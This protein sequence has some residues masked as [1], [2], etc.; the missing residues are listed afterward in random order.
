VHFE[1]RRDDLHACRVVDG[2]HAV[3]EPGQALLEIDSFGLTTNNI[4][5]AVFG[6]AMSYW[7][8]FPADDGWG[9]VPVWGFADV[10][11]GGDTDLAGGSRVFGYFPPSSTLVVLPE[12]IDSRGF[13]DAS[14]HRANLPAAYN[15]YALVEGLP[16]YEQRFE[17]QQMLLWPL[18]FTSFL[19]D[20]F[21]GGEELF[22]A[23]TAIVSSASSKTA[24]SAAF[25][26]ARREG[27]EVVG[28]TSP[29]RVE[30]VEG[31]GVYDHVVGYPEVSSL[32]ATPAVYVDIAG[33]TGVRAAVHGHFGDELRHSA[34]VGATHWDAPADQGG[35]DLP[36]PQPE[37]FFAPDH[38]RRRS[39]DWG[40]EG[41]DRRVAEA[42]VPF[43]EWASGWLEIVRGEGPEAVQ[44]AYLE[45]L[46][47]RTDPSVGH[48]LRP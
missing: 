9:R 4:T 33:D 41:L 44:A 12:R 10:A 1:V 32:P 24:L 23:G 48:V 22:G 47:G 6:E 29:S 2:D 35:G 17:E 20:D 8:F 43:V 37:F 42:W 18:F 3:L 39:S 30:F 27:V 19:I 21:L 34:V 46:D 31:L 28:L 26:L 38:V 40:R 45:L 36:G 11:D 16:L 5:Y 15:S 14:P 7:S 25:L 13:V